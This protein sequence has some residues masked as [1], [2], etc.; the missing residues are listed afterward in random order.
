MTGLLAF[1]EPLL[2]MIVFLACMV[3]MSWLA[4]RI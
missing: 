2:Y 3:A 4:D 1:A